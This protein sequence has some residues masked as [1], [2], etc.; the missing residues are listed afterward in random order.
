L[1]APFYD[2]QGENTST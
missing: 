2:Y 1:V